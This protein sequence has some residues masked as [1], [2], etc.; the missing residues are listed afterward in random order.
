M[1]YTKCKNRYR[2]GRAQ[3]ELYRTYNG[4]KNRCYNTRN[5][6]FMHYGGRG[7]KVCDRWL[8]HKHGFWS[9]VADVGERPIGN[10]LDRIDTNGPYSPNNCRWA[11][12]TTQASNQRRNNHIVGVSF[13]KDRNKF[14]AYY[15]KD[16]IFIRKRFSSIDD[17]IKFAKLHRS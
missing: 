6:K 12:S 2:D 7:I 4:M 5:S 13:E 8:D 14:V 9:F 15:R 10:T 17:A 3:H 16:G 11:N 1:E